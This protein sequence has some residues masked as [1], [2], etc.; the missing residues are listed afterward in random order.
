MLSSFPSVQTKI[1]WLARNL[2]PSNYVHSADSP[3]F[4]IWKG[5]GGGYQTLAALLD[6]TS[7]TREIRIK[8]QINKFVSAEQQI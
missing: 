3:K 5:G 1:W 2:K 4:L 8:K 6:F 7:K